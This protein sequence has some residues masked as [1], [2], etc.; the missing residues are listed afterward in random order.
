VNRNDGTP[1]LIIGSPGEDI[2]T[3][4]TG[5]YRDG[6]T[7]VAEVVDGGAI[8]YLRGDSKSWV[9]QNSD[10]V[11]GG[12]E[13]GDQFGWSVAATPTRF[14]VGAPYEDA[15]AAQ[16]TNGGGTLLFTHETSA[17]G[18]PV[19]THWIDQ[20][21]AALTSAV[22]AGDALGYA[23]AAIDYWPSGGGVGS[24]NTAFAIAVPW[25]D[26][27]DN[28]VINSGAV[29][30]IQMDS[31]GAITSAINYAQGDTLGDSSEASD[32][33]G[34]SVGLYNTNP[35]IAANNS[36]LKLAIGVPDENYAT[37]DDDGM[38]HVTGVAAPAAD[39]DTVVTDPSA[40]ANGKFGT[41]VSMSSQGVY[42]TAPGTATVNCLAWSAVPAASQQTVTA[43]PV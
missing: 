27:A 1:V 10:G 15:G 20:E 36:R 41:N 22:E 5:A 34:V 11:G 17:E 19:N 8:V 24:A 29:H 30:L 6:D 40:N 21:D 35:M 31:S 7:E 9:D 4:T 26:L 43:P 23:V 18:T 28:T 32:H 12:V 25:E 2:Q 37:T 38:V 42:I 14:I 39:I 3:D 16:L 33:I 13:A